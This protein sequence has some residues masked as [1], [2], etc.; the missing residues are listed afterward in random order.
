MVQL[1]INHP[2][3]VVFA[4]WYRKYIQN[5]HVPNRFSVNNLQN[6]RLKWWEQQHVLCMIPTLTHQGRKT[7]IVS[8][9]LQTRS[10]K[11]KSRSTTTSQIQQLPGRPNTDKYITLGIQSPCQMM[12]GV[13]N[14]LLSKVFKFHD[15]SQKVIGSLGINIITYLQSSSNWANRMNFCEFHDISA[16]CKFSTI[17]WICEDLVSTISTYIT[18]VVSLILQKPHPCPKTTPGSCNQTPGIFAPAKKD[19]IELSTEIPHKPGWW[20]KRSPSD[21]FHCSLLPP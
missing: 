16:T 15:H 10:C 4:I 8:Y 9:L 20:K 1:Y 7:C 19:Y 14:H 3:M 13:Y 11:K 21:H 5:D 12:I 6:L 18:F 17:N 2:S